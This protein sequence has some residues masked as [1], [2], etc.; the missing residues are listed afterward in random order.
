MHTKA[1]LRRLCFLSFVL[2]GNLECASGSATSPEPVPVPEAQVCVDRPPANTLAPERASEPRVLVDTHG[3]ELFAEAGFEGAFVLLDPAANLRREVNPAQ[4]A[5][6]HLPASTFKIPNTLI[7][8][9]TGV[10]PD[11]TFSLPWDG[12]KRWV[13]AWNRDHDLASA[14]KYSVVWFYQEVARRIGEVRMREW[15]EKLDYGNRDIGGGIDQF[16]LDGAI[17]ISPRQQ[18]EFLMH[19][20]QNQLPVSPESRE[21]VDQITVL[22]IGDNHVLRGKTGLTLEA[23]NTVGWLIGSVEHQGQRVFFATLLLAEGEQFDRVMPARHELT[24]AFL[25]RYGV[26][27]A[28]AS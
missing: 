16:W 1:V 26:L 8:L 4:V 9:N 13:K 15:V 5:V 19:L 18:V 12:V 20:H 23:G 11:V 27:P 28:P 7:G 17:R 2:L 25:H 21:I 3:A 24:R 10:I 14:M 22:E 6:G